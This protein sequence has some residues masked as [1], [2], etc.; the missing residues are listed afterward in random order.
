[1]LHFGSWVGGDMDGLPDVHAKTIRESCARHHALIVNRYFLEAQRL[2]EK[3]SQSER[4][5]PDIP[6]PLRDRIEH[7][8]SVVPAARASAP[9]GHDEMPYRVLLGQI[10]E[11]LRATYDHRSGQYERVEQ[12]TDDLQIIVNSLEANR[13]RYAGLFLIRRFLR[14]VRTFGL[15]LA[16]LDVR[17][18]AEVHRQIVGR[19]LDEPG[20]DTRPAAERIERLRDA[21]AR[22]ESPPEVLEAAG[23][24]ALWVFEAMDYCRHRYGQAAVGSY[25][26]SMAR[27][28]DDVLSVL[29]LARW[30]GL[31]DNVVRAGRARRRAAVRIG[32]GARCG[33]ADARPPARRPDLSRAPGRT[34]QPADRDDRLC[35]QQQGIGHHRVALGAAQG[36]G[37]HARRLRRRRACSCWCSTAAAARS[38][39]AAAGPKP[40]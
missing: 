33:R 32:G 25:V 18:N 6:Q 14:R 24:R 16:T 11:R 39:A 23:K 34:R 9:S 10:A 36:A 40:S 13:G 4:R 7:Y 22:D 12:L 3:L 15:H 38:V 2:A 21:L 5:T 19:A 30:A 31:L 1:M 26:V 8:K 37:G 29:L 27:D 35:R 20:W 28:I 17:Q